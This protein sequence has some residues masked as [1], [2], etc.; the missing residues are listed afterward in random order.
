MTQGIVISALEYNSVDADFEN[1]D[2]REL[3]FLEV[4]G[5]GIGNNV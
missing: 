2:L 4:M 5:K 3:T 1:P